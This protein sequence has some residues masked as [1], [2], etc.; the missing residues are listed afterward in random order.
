MAEAAEATLEEL[1]ATTSALR[2]A[3]WWRLMLYAVTCVLTII[4]VLVLSRLVLRA[5]RGLLAELSQVMRRL[6]EGQLSADV[7]GRDRNDEI[8]LMAKAVE[9][10]KQNARRAAV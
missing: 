6:A 1:A 5:V 3:A 2:A 10:F 8:G 9:V 7:P 4:V